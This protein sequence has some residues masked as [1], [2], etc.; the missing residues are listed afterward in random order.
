MSAKV[1]SGNLAEAWSELYFIALMFDNFPVN[2]L[3]GCST[4]TGFSQETRLFTWTADKEH[5]I[6]FVVNRTAENTFPASFVG[7]GENEM[8]RKFD[9][10]SF[11]NFLFLS[12]ELIEL[13]ILLFDFFLD[14]NRRYSN[15]KKFRFFCV[16][17]HIVI[18]DVF[19]D[20]VLLEFDDT[21]P[22]LHLWC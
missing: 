7:F 17:F 18:F 2:V 15:I 12:F 13:L 8:F 20:F 5:V 21:F 6:S 19:E 3:N 9:R 10:F 14:L 16:F 22:V 1:K 4:E 11:S